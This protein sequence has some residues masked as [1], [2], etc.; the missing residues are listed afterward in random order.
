MEG[1]VEIKKIEQTYCNIPCV[2]RDCKH[3]LEEFTTTKY[4]PSGFRDGVWREELIS[5]WHGER[6]SKNEEL[7]KIRHEIYTRAQAACDSV[8]TN[9]PGCTM[10]T[11]RKASDAFDNIANEWRNMKCPFYEV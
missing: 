6:C 3:W 2:G 11:I 9:T 7:G 4:Y 1:K 5:I 10:R 8:Y